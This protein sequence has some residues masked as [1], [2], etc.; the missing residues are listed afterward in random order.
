M[1]NVDDD[2]NDD[3]KSSVEVEDMGMEDEE[4]VLADEDG[5]VYLQ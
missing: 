2:K 3:D 5:M 4:R 1:R